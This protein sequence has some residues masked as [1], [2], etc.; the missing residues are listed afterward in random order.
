MMPDL[1]EKKEQQ[2]IIPDGYMKDGKGRL[3]P[4]DLVSDI[5]KLR[6][7]TVQRIVARAQALQAEMRQVKTET[8]SDIQAFVEL[9]SERYGVEVGGVKGNVQLMSFDGKYRVQRNI[10]DYIVFDERLQVAKELIDNCIHRW[11]EGARSEIRALVQDAFQT[12]KTGNI[13]T[14]RVLGLRRLDITDPEWK[15]AMQA[16]SDSI[17]ITGSKTYIRIY[18]RV[19]QSDQFEPISLDIAGL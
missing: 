5:D 7:D 13:S 10:A 6:N 14:S 11:S 16:I 15:Q 8:L 18:Q 1:Q 3:T 12:D 4:I 2:D 19:G 17:Q 9:S